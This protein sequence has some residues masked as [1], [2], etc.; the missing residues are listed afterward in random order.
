MH[1]PVT[2]GKRKVERAIQTLK[3]LMLTN[4]EGGND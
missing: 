3:S 4:L 1:T 2:Y